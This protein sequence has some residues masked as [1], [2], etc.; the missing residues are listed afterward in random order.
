MGSTNWSSSIVFNGRQS[1]LA[2]PIATPIG[3]SRTIPRKRLVTNVVIVSI[4]RISIKGVGDENWPIVFGQWTR[5]YIRGH[6]AYGAE[7]GIG[8]FSHLA[9]CERSVEAPVGHRIN[10]PGSRCSHWQAHLTQLYNGRP[11][12]FHTHFIFSPYNWQCACQSTK[13]T[14]VR[15]QQSALAVIY[16]ATTLFYYILLR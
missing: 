15:C 16:F 7:W 13:F 9:R 4:G 5:D 12:L 8:L 6:S 1:G 14:K 10:S 2:N 3:L 11:K